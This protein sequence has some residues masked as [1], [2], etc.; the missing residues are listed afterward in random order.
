M[1]YNKRSISLIFTDLWDRKKYVAIIK[2]IRGYDYAFCEF[3][4]KF[5]DDNDLRIQ[6]YIYFLKASALVH[7][8]F[9]CASRWAIF[10]YLDRQG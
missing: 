4:T 8:R 1:R 10:L 9:C 6:T 3:P 2:N 5:E 7:D